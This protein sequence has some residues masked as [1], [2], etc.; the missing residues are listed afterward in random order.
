M[1]LLVLWYNN[2]LDNKLQLNQEIEYVFEEVIVWKASKSEVKLYKSTNADHTWEELVEH[3]VDYDCNTS[4]HNTTLGRAT[5][6]WHNCDIIQLHNYRT[7]CRS[8]S[9]SNIIEPLLYMNLATSFHFVRRHNTNIVTII[10]SW[11]FHKNCTPVHEEI[12]ERSFIPSSMSINVITWQCL[13]LS[14]MIFTFLPWDD[15]DLSCF[16]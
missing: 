8:E 1:F 4:Y 12:S 14:S 16:M 9:S 10:N 6:V 5:V 11:F 15:H 2:F 13:Y 3:N 7:S